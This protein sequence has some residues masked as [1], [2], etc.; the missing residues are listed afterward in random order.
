MIIN[1]LSWFE[2]WRNEE[3]HEYGWTVIYSSYL[4]SIIMLRFSHFLSENLDF[5]ITSESTKKKR[6]SWS[7]RSLK[8]LTKQ[9]SN[10]R[11]L[12]PTPPLFDSYQILEYFKISDKCV[13]CIC[14]RVILEIQQF[15][16]VA[17]I[18]L[19]LCSVSHCSLALRNAHSSTSLESL[20]R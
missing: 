15:T 17:L 4:E 12:S 5:L 13:W 1:Y 8:L 11:F 3:P 2:R 20:Q 19:E 18:E 6:F 10:T 9:A 14:S 7:P 16:S